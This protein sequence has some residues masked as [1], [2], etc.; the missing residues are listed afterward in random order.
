MKFSVLTNGIEAGLLEHDP[1]HGYSFQ[2]LPKYLGM[3]GAHPVSFSLPLR[4]DPYR[5]EYL[6][7]AFSNLLPEGANREKLC[8]ARKIDPE[9]NLSLLALLVSQQHS[10]IGALDFER[11]E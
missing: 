8:V 1:A 5:S 9:D 11:L 2:Y 7:A 4:P 10:F 3:A 6:F